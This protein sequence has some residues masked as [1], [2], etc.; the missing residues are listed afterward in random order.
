ML[1]DEAVDAHYTPP[2][3]ARELLRHVEQLPAGSI[4][5]FAAGG[6]ELLLQA[7]RR[8]PTRE[9]VACDISRQVVCNISKEQRAW[10]IGR[11]NFL[12]LRSRAASRVLR[13]AKGGVALCLANPPFSYRGG[14]RWRVDTAGGTTVLCSPAVAFLLTAIEYLS[15]GGW[16]LAIIPANS[17]RSQKDEAAINLLSRAGAFTVLDHYPR[18]SFPSCTS[19]TVSISFRLHRELIPHAVRSCPERPSR[20]E[21]ELVRGCAPMHRAVPQCKGV[22]PIVHTTDL[23]DHCVYPPTLGAGG[24]GRVVK[25][26]AVLL[27]R[28]GNPSSDKI[29]LYP[30]SEYVVLSDCVFGITCSSPAHALYLLNLLL[31]NWSAIHQA[32]HGTCAPYMTTKDLIG[33]LFSLGVRVRADGEQKSSDNRLTLGGLGYAAPV[34]RSQN[35]Y[36]I[37]AAE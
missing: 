36:K 31:A 4:A 37:G 21:V 1:R 27:P 9:I 24:T 15:P 34:R 33:A 13:V 12:S 22:T 35:R 8:W 17:L 3:M 16:L 18:G 20:L 11:C 26:P 6:G 23:Q 14:K 5:D 7:A 10:S 30:A 29:A 32:Y 2:N 25:G 28:V 19:Q